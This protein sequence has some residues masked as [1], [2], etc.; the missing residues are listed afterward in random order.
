MAKMK[1]PL[2]PEEPPAVLSESDLTKLLKA[3]E[4]KTHEDRRDAAMIRLLIDS[5][6]R[7]AELAG[8]KVADVDF[9]NNVA[10][11]MGKGRRPRACPFGRKTAVALDRYIRIRAQHREAQRPELWLSWAGHTGALT[12]NGIYQI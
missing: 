10:L 8:L 2:I 6:M 12:A 5:G 1:P 3:W 11:V 9:E 4:G 7:R